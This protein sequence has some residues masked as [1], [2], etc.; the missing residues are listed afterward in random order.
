MAALET[1]A[2]PE[3][4]PGMK[5]YPVRGSNPPAQGE[6]LLTSPEVE[7]DMNLA[8]AGRIELPARGSTIRCSTTELCRLLVL[9]V[10]F[11]PRPP[12]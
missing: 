3:G 5:W 6:N 9:R 2:H 12:G 8:P 10:G 1:A 4:V 11:E 7:R